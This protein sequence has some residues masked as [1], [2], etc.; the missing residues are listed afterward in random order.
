MTALLTAALFVA[1]ALLGAGTLI[2][3]WNTYR[4]RFAELGA[5][6]RAVE[7][8]I[9]VRFARHDP[10]APGATVYRM[11][12]TPPREALPRRPDLPLPVAA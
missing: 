1:A 8:G 12:A 4:D 2:H 11:R 3:A 6:L 7:C 10:A 9:V 5:Q